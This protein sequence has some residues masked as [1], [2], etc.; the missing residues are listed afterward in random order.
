MIRKAVLLVILALLASHVASTKLA[1]R[2]LTRRLAEVQAV[3]DAITKTYKRVPGGRGTSKIP[4]YKD[5]VSYLI[6]F[7]P[8]TAKVWGNQG[9]LISATLKDGTTLPALKMSAEIFC[10][11]WNRIAH[12]LKVP[13][14]GDAVFEIEVTRPY[15]GDSH[16]AESTEQWLERGRKLDF[17]A[18]N[19]D[20]NENECHGACARREI[21]FW[22]EESGLASYEILTARLGEPVEYDIDKGCTSN[23]GVAWRLAP[24]RWIAIARSVDTAGEVTMVAYLTDE[25][26]GAIKR[27][28]LPKIPLPPS[29]E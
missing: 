20:A 17:N 11:E 27:K 16:N 14:S 23:G 3:I 22:V 24:D 1:E 9:Y 13:P 28:E 25:L 5:H 29:C 4:R 6:G 8:A 10:N 12:E 7:D 19:K 21:T 26:M 15:I 2:R 18:P